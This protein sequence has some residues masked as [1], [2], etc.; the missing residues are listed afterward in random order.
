MSLFFRST[1][2]L[3]I[4]FGA[5]C[6]N[7]PASKS[8]E[9]T[10]APTTKPVEANTAKPKENRPEGEIIGT[11]AKNSK[12]AKL[13]L[14]QTFRQVSDLIGTPDDI[15][16]H[17]TGKRWIPFY[18]GGDAQRLQVYYKNEGCLT[19]TGGNVFGGGGNELIRITVDP[20]GGCWRP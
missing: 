4:A 14:G 3:I 15:T 11:P 12:F 7:Q 2:L 19:Y 8:S 6:A 10:V 9:T 17:E 5:G 13:Q 1:L 20:K 16:R 18:Y